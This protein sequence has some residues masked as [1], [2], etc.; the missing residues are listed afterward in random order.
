MKKLLLLCSIIGIGISTSAQ[1]LQDDFEGNGNIHTWFGDN[2]NLDTNLTNP[3]QNGINTS[4]SVLEYHDVGG[5]YANIRFEA[6]RNLNLSQYNTF[7]LKVYVP[8]S[9]ITGN[10][11]NQISLKL[12]DGTLAA[13]WSTQSEIIKPLV[14]NQWQTVTFD[15]VNDPFINLDPN[16]LPPTQRTDFNR[17]VLQVNGENNNHHVLAYFDDFLYF[18]STVV[19]SLPI[20][21][22]LIWSDEFNTN[23]TIDAS[24]W[25]HQ[26]TIPVGTSWFNGEVQHYTNRTLNS[27][28]SNGHLI[29]TARRESFTDQGVTKQFTSA[30]L[31]SKF[32]F[33][34]GKV[35][36]R[37]KLPTGPGTWPAIWMLGQNINENGAYWQTQGFGTTGWPACGEIDI[38]EHWGTNQDFIQ[39]AMHTPSS[40]GNTTNKGGRVVNNVSTSFH[41]YTLEWYPD[42]MVFSVDSI[43]HYTYQPAVRNPQTWPFDAP[44][45]MLFNIAVLPSI[46]PSFTQSTMEIDYIRIYQETPVSVQEIEQEELLQ[47]FPNPVDDQLNILANK[48]HNEKVDLAIYS[49]QGK[50]VYSDQVAFQ[51]GTAQIKEL[52]HLKSGIYFVRY[53]LRDKP[54]SIKI[55]K[56]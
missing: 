10:A 51:N 40:S 23:G 34:Y 37:A 35:E 36:V 25:F 3:Q 11:P 47:F 13:P 21:D 44:Q 22:R 17:I 9:G 4:A 29:M 7:S 14:L 5:Q 27:V 54:Y 52:N 45:Y 39:S 12:Q 8:S 53:M 33:Q 32:A 41:T 50:L 42:R 31:N 43:V 26:T 49:A 2:C 20:Y 16:S 56:Q 30:R 48:G 1:S 46:L 19:N 24:K 55:I 18:D 28:V 6:G 38:M 15:F